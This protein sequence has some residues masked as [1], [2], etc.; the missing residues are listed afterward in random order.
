MQQSELGPHGENEN[1]QASKQQ[2][3][4]SYPVSLALPNT[5]L[6]RGVGV[7]CKVL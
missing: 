1:A 3:G 2:N 4:D 6:N 5:S 7:K